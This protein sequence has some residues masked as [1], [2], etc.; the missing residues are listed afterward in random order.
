MKKRPIPEVLHK[1]I[2]PELAA[3]IRRVAELSKGDVMITMVPPGATTEFCDRL[4]AYV[5][6]LLDVRLPG[7]MV[8]P[9]VKQGS[10]LICPYCAA[11][12]RSTKMT[13]LDDH[14]RKCEFRIAITR[15]A[16]EGMAMDKEY[17]H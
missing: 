2:T 7:P 10:G 13:S 16:M 17:G 1:H 9:A 6:F 4:R 11:P 8:L 3:A 15:W 12:V 5:S 14:A